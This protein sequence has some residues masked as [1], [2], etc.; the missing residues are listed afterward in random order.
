MVG[1]DHIVLAEARWVA[2]ETVG[3]PGADH[4][5]LAA[6]VRLPGIH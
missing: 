3:L 2:V 1:I 4:L 5:A 6:R